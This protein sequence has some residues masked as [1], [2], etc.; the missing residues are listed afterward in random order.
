[1]AWSANKTN[2]LLRHIDANKGERSIYLQSRAQGHKA[3]AIFINERTPKRGGISADDVK[4]KIERFFTSA[5]L[6]KREG[7]NILFVEG[8]KALGPEFQEEALLSQGVSGSGV[9]SG[10][11]SPSAKR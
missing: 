10:R 7:R 5:G 3:A 6:K 4:R 2:L 1:M 9:A 8:R 11:G